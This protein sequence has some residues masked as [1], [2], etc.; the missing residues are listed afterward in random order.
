MFSLRRRVLSDVSGSV[1][2]RTYVVSPGAVGVV[3]VTASLE[4][5]LVEQYRPSLDA[6]LLEIPAGMR[7]VPG[8]EPLVTARR[9]L[10]E[11]AGLEA[12]E[13]E[14][15]GSCIGSAAVSNSK[16]EIFLATD[17]RDVPREPHGPEEESMV[18]H[19]VPFDEALTMVETG[20]IQDAKTIVGLLLVARRRGL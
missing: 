4:V 8:E 19:M 1:F 11:E 14:R 3:A 9:E 15:I 5:V 10:A 12:D 17:L 20:S 7:D 16:V 13:W 18:I 6:P 2:D